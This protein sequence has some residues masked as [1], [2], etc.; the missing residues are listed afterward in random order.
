M[1]VFKDFVHV[2]AFWKGIP[3][4]QGS[5][6]HTD[7]IRNATL[8]EICLSDLERVACTIRSTYD[9]EGLKTWIVMKILSLKIQFR[10]PEDK[11]WLDATSSIIDIDTQ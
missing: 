4:T 10:I 5:F 3:T 2:K 8:S 7:S 6:K 9:K 11:D 1:A